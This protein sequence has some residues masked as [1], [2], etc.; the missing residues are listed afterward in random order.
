M[1]SFRA[2]TVYRIARLHV[3]AIDDVKRER[4]DARYIIK[5]VVLFSTFDI[6]SFGSITQSNLKLNV[7]TII[8]VTARQGV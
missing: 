1:R 8:R 7:S 6:P 3:L 5:I 2:L 4:R